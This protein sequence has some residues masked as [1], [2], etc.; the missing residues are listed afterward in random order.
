VNSRETDKATN[1]KGKGPVRA[2]YSFIRALKRI[3]R[4]SARSTWY[5]NVQLRRLIKVCLFFFILYPHI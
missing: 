3:T 2:S 5:S 4:T 1:Q